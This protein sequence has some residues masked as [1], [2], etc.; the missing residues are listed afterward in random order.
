[1]KNPCTLKGT[2]NSSACGILLKN[3]NEDIPIVFVKADDAYKFDSFEQGEN[4]YIDVQDLEVGDT[5]EAV[6]HKEGNKYDWYFSFQK[7]L[8]V[9]ALISLFWVEMNNY[10]GELYL[11]LWDFSNAIVLNQTCV[12]Y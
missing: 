6:K 2:Q 7:H 10:V 8:Q 3:I 1:M 9:D 5:D 11:F 4:T 12:I